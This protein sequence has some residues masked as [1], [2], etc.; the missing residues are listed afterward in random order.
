[1]KNRIV[2]VVYSLLVVGMVVFCAVA[3]Q[4]LNACARREFTIYPYYPIDSILKGLLGLLLG[5]EQI[6][7]LISRRG[8]VRVV[9]SHLLAACALITVAILGVYKGASALQFVANNAN[10][11]WVAAG[12]LLGTS[13]RRD[14]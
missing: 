8:S 5:A 7:C 3:A 13:F 11:F 10:I 4:Y 9:W 6:V 1:M 2:R 12:Y 14:W